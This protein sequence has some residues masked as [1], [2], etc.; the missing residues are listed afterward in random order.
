MDAI[1]QCCLCQR[2]W[3]FSLCH[4]F[5]GFG[6]PITGLT[7]SSPF[8]LCFLWRCLF[9]VFIGDSALWLVLYLFNT[10]VLWTGEKINRRS[11]HTIRLWG[12]EN[13]V[14]GHKSGAFTMESKF[15]WSGTNH[16]RDTWR[17][18]NNAAES[19]W[20]SVFVADMFSFFHSKLMMILVSRAVLPHCQPKVLVG[21]PL[22]EDAEHTAGDSWAPTPFCPRSLCFIMPLGSIENYLTPNHPHQLSSWIKVFI[23]ILH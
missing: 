9:S 18:P 21:K 13:P 11:Q 12:G 2:L 10:I 6:A 8:L 19:E 15:F 22:G 5:N 17:R 20:A 14:C 7:P 3:P 1:H 23:W 16:L 4:L